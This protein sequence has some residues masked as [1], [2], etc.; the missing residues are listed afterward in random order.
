MSWLK[1]VTNRD[2]AYWMAR[3]QSLIASNTKDT[4]DGHGETDLKWIHDLIDEVQNNLPEPNPP[5]D[6]N[7]RMA[8]SLA[9]IL[10]LWY[11]QVHYAKTQD[12][13]RPTNIRQRAYWRRLDWIEEM[14]HNMI[15]TSCVSTYFPGQ[16]W[17]DPFDPESRGGEFL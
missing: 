10:G 4:E 6:G 3:V 9:A 11:S 7:M 8:A 13:N 15:D 16:K 17:Q 1:D 14:I 5:Y 2:E 12:P